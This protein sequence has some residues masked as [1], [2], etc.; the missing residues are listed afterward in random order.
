MDE[1]R[2]DVNE[3]FEQGQAELGDLHG[4]RDRLIRAGLAARSKRSDNHVQLA[5]G[6]AIVLIAALLVATFAYVRA[7]NQLIPGGLRSVPS[8]T[9]LTQPLDVPDSTPV[10]RYH[11]LANFD[12]IDAM[13]WD[14]KHSGTADWGSG[15]RVSNP[16]V[17]L[18]AHETTITDRERRVVLTGDFRGIQGLG[19]WADD[20]T[21]YCQITP[22]DGTTVYGPADAKLPSTLQL[23]RFGLQPRNVAQVGSVV[24]YPRVVAC[25]VRGD[26]AVVVRVGEH[27]VETGYSVV[28]L[29]TGRIVWTHTL[30]ESQWS[31]VVASPD[32]QYVAENTGPRDSGPA[33]IYGRDGT[34]L[35]RIPDFVEAFSWDGSLVVTDRGIGTVPVRLVRWQDGT[36]VWT[37]PRGE[38][39]Y[40]QRAMP[41]PGGT[42]VAIGIADPA[43][44]QIEN[45]PITLGDAPGDLYLIA[46][47]GHVILQVNDIHIVEARDSY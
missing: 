10:I 45:D 46:A 23:V 40:F 11:D 4:V 38:G 43:F 14:G 2:R 39:F 19:A 26:R 42:S 21:S 34:A 36:V 5:T 7:G 33:T 9:E 24:D 29:S 27:G 17:N 31:H 32:G 13:T 3:A 18:F 30:D 8:P 15:F 20:E 44:P 12:Q 35:A 47:D 25:G 41:E 37:G 22:D 16:Q 6:L 1:L 28:E